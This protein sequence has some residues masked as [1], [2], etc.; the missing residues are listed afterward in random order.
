MIA[1]IGQVAVL[2]LSAVLL[3]GLVVRTKSWWAGRRGPPIAQL[4][5]DLARLARKTPVY[6]AVTTP[7]FRLA[8]WVVLVSAVGAALVVPV[9]G[10]ASTIAFPGDF[11]WFV[12][13]GGLGRM[14][15]VLAALDTGSP[16]EGMGAAREASFAT[17]VE[18]T[19]FLAFGAGILV[20]G[21]DT[22]SGILLHRPGSAAEWAVWGG[23]VVA[24]AIVVQVES[25]R[26]PIDDP[27]THLE[28]T[29]IHEVTILDHSGPD[30]AALQ[31]A[32]GLRLAAGLSLWTALVLPSGSPVW[33]A[34]PV[35]L[36][37]TAAAA[38]ALG[39]VES[40]VARLRMRAIP[41]YILVGGS[42]GALAVV[43]TLWVGP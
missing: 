5:W 8:P 29:M 24:L 40:L 23:M 28:L 38:I 33:A 25:A 36:A 20:S 37:G 14:A 13:L 26:M 16:F 9:L 34:I 42:A 21:S 4:G 10:S 11:V 6:S 7:L 27:T 19:T 43:A 35:Q 15:Q 41:S 32:A 17:L 22:L 30:L 1:A 18:P 12:Y 3:P 39:T 2:A 31:L